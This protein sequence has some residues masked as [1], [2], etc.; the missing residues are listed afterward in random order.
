[1]RVARDVFEDIVA[2]G[3]N[4]IPR[5]FRDRL[6]NV[7]IV[8]EDW[9]SRDAVRAAGASHSAQL[10]GF[11]R[12]VPLPRR[13]HQY[14]LALPDKITIYQRPIEM[15]CTSIEQMCTMVIR[16]LQH[17]VAHHFGLEDERLHEIGAF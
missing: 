17:E 6:N 9:P 2:T 13:T 10:L 16:V 12:G 14:G 15:R 3:V 11:Y 5:R 8:V 4:A 7:E 1:M